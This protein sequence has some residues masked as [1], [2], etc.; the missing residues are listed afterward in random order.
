[1]KGSADFFIGLLN[2][3]FF[4]AVAVVFFSC[5]QL[6]GVVPALSDKAIDVLFQLRGPSEPSQD[7]VI[8]GIDEDSLEQISSWPF[9]RKRHAKL[10]DRLKKAK[11]V[12]FDVLFSEPT[13]QDDI[14]SQAMD[15]GPPVILAVAHNYQNQILYPAPTISHYSGIGRIEVILGRDGVVRQIGPVFLSGDTSL[16]TF[17]LAMLQAAGGVT[18]P[19]LPEG[20]VTIN[21]YGPEGTFLYISYADVLAGLYSE[22]FFKDRY[23]LIGAEALGIGDSHVTPFSKRYPTPGVEIQAAILNNLIDNNWL[24]PVPLVPWLLMIFVALIAVFIWPLQGEKWNLAVNLLLIGLIA[25]CSIYFF[26]QA[27]LLDPVPPVFFLS[28]SFLVHLVAERIW[29][30]RKIFSEMNRLD[31]QLEVRLKNVYTNIPSQFFKRPVKVKGTGTRQYL[32][33]LQAG[34]RALSLQHHFIEHLLKE[35]LPPLILWDRETSE[36]ILANTMY[37]NFWACV[38]RK[39]AALPTIDDFIS[40][41]EE[42]FTDEN[43]VAV[44]LSSLVGEGKGMVVDIGLRVLGRKRFYRVHMQVVTADDMS[45]HGILAVL[46]DITEVKELEQLQSE[47]V[48]VVSH[49]LKLPLTVIY[50]YGEI[51]AQTLQGEEKVYIDSICSQ[52]L[53]LNRLIEDFLDIARI[54]HGR[55]EIRK[56]PLD[57]LNLVHE[58]LSAVSAPAEKKSITLETKLPHRVSPIIGD[59][60]LLLQ[61]VI[62]LLDNA[63]KFSPEQTR[64]TLQLVE[65]EEQ[66]LLRVSDQGP[67]VPEESRKDI[68]AKFHRGKHAPQEEEFGLGL[69]FVLQVV[70]KHGGKISLEQQ[71]G[72]GASFC[73][74]L[75]KHDIV[76]KAQ[77]A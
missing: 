70:Q 42:N 54:E 77:K 59:Y 48:S 44:D 1:M 16:P 72:A 40:F 49:E 66:F 11:V 27:M 8:V 12:G 39:D 38:A 65:E 3:F 71:D 37:N 43:L 64:I 57:M 34:V 28:V 68:F 15:A 45:F 62:N 23:V 10:L 69:N 18:L 19:R 46:T 4:L 63:V 55:Q 13:D 52:A 31:Q 24:H 7:I 25:T 60:T 33:H 32:M 61:A 26:S 5:F 21:Y 6:G 17:S 36:V 51:L 74:T 35:D 14:F 58:A 56:L 29:T 2:R 75:P 76:E 67:G 30:A 53:R 20:E 9:E 22:D 50:G 47:I 73:M 41:L